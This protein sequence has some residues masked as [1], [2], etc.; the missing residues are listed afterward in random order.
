MNFQIM[1]E[2]RLE[3]SIKALM[4]STANK[5]S[6]FARL[7]NYLTSPQDA[8]EMNKCL[9]SCLL[10]SSSYPSAIFAEMDTAARSIWFLIE[11]FLQFSN[12]VKTSL[13]SLIAS[14]QMM[15]SSNLFELVMFVSFAKV[16]IRDWI[17]QSSQLNIFQEIPAAD[18][19]APVVPV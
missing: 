14:C 11:K 15:R 9:M 19:V 2:R 4:R 17:F 18:P 6:S 7:N 5:S 3:D 8:L 16:K 13:A 10:V 12:I 1:I